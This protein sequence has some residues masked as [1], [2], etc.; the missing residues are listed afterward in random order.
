VFNDV[1]NALRLRQ[2]TTQRLSLPR[3]FALVAGVMATALV[4]AAAGRG[5][6]VEPVLVPSGSM[7]P[8]IPAGSRLVVVAERLHRDQP[9]RG[10]IVTLADPAYPGRRLVKRVIALA[11]ETITTA[12]GRVM[13]DGE[14]LE[15]P[16]LKSGSVTELAEPVVVP[17]GHYY[18]MGDARLV[19][20]DSR[21]FGP[22]ALDS[23][24]GR[25]RMI[26]APLDHAGTIH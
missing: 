21:A 24:E 5:L 16:W 22:V 23:I 7:V 15:E 20:V 19:S 11:G 26:A 17:A 13:I 10:E 12:A 3:R 14:A 25:G 6:I 4:I 1:D 2:E 8:T 18:V 9:A